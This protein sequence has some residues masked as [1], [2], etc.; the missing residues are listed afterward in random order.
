MKNLPKAVD[1]A[2][3]NLIAGRKILAC[4]QNG[5]LLTKFTN[6]KE[7]V[8]SSAFLALQIRMPAFLHFFLWLI[9]L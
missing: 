4:C 2:K 5:K 9:D 7:K 8:V 6:S 1:F 3:R